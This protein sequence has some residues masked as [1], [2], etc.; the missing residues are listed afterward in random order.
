MSRVYI[1]GAGASA[2]AGYPSAHGLWSFVRQHASIDG[3]LQAIIRELAERYQPDHVDDPDLESLF[4]LLDVQLLLTLR[5]WQG[6]TDWM[7]HRVR[8]IAALVKAFLDYQRL[9]QR[10]FWNDRTNVL[11]LNQSIVARVYRDWQGCLS[12]DDTIISFN[13]DIL[14]E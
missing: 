13:W 11:P 10:F 9:F 2:F 7:L 5:A 4:T 1:L 8:F 3:D 12:L 14:H 6:N